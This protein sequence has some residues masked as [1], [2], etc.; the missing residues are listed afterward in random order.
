MKLSTATK[1]RLAGALYG[2]VAVARRSVGRPL[3]PVVCRRG[4]VVW[5]LNLREGIQLSIYLFGAFEPV[6]ARAIRRLLPA[7]GVAVDIGANIGAQALP[8]ARHVGPQ[9]RVI[10]VEPTASALARLRANVALNPDLSGTVTVCPSAI[11]APGEAIAETYYSAWPVSHASDRHA[12]HWGVSGSAAGSAALTLDELLARE[13]VTRLDLVKIDVD[14]GEL[15]VLRG[16]AATLAAV[17]PA[18]VLELSPYALEEHGGSLGELLAILAGARY[19]L[20]DERT[21]TPL[22]TAADALAR[23]I[24]AAGSINVVAIPVER[25]V[26]GVPA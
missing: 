10:A 17:R 18:L 23:L 3:D 1:I 15:A 19:R 11:L 24:P 8:M 9:G 2:V 7:G 16:A 6:T 13:S 4:G 22:P 12:V 25:A 26:E 21:F 14:G 20:L 5:S